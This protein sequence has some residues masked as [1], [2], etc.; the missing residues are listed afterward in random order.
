[1]LEQILQSVKEEE[2][3]SV[4]RK[5]EAQ[6]TADQHI[7]QASDKVGTILASAQEEAK[8]YRLEALEAARQTVSRILEESSRQTA[9]QIRTVNQ[10]TE[11][12][13]E[14]IATDILGRIIHGNC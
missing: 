12:R 4:T 8:R 3:L 10:Q 5:E 11:P 9:E 14:A 1:M 7:Q 2:A 13:I 6:A